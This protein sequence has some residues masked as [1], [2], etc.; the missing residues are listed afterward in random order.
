MVQDLA[1]LG[2]GIESIGRSS[3]QTGVTRRK[4]V[5]SKEDCVH[6]NINKYTLLSWH[7]LNKT[8]VC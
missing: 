2:W 1:D 7:I 3:S 5:T 8:L 4:E 6:L